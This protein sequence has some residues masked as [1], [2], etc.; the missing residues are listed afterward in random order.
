LGDIELAP[1]ADELPVRSWIEAAFQGKV[2]APER[3]IEPERA[4]AARRGA[5]EEEVAARKQQDV[6]QDVLAALVRARR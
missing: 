6:D 2:V 3:G 1:G 5:L 4:L